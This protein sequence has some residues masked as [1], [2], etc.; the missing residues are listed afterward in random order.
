MRPVA[1]RLEVQAAAATEVQ[2]LVAG[3]GVQTAVATEAQNQQGLQMAQLQQQRQGLGH[4]QQQLASRQT[5]AIA[6]Q[7]SL[8]HQQQQ[9]QGQAEAG[10]ALQLKQW[11]Q[12]SERLCGFGLRL[13][14]LASK[15]EALEE[16]ALRE[17]IEPTGFVLQLGWLWVHS[18]LV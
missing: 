14:Y 17:A 4:S 6:A 3:L 8:A 11:Q 7:Q 1:A 13:G 10:N 16:N 9:L 12:Q 5:G 18:P 2:A 15:V